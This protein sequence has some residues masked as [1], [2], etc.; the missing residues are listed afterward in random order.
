MWSLRPFVTLSPRKRANAVVRLRNN[1][2]MQ[3]PVSGGR[4]F[5]TPDLID[6]ERPRQYLQDAH[7][8]F[9]GTDKRVYWNAHI[10]TAGKDFWGK[11]SEAASD[12]ARAMLSEEECE[13][14]FVF[15]FSPV[16]YDAWGHP[17]SFTLEDNELTYP[18]FGGLSYDAYKGKLEAELIANEPP[19]VYESFKIDREFEDGIGLYVVVDAEYIDKEVVERV[20]NRFLAV[21]ETDWQSDTPVPREKLPFET[22]IEFLMTV[23][24]EKR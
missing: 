8:Y 24:P 11:V 6:P 15:N 13:R 5:G 21:G 10:F 3:K 9:C 20:I 17:T 4:F 18:Q 14:E 23:P 16:E 22:E 19:E 12:R 2:R 1:I 7:V